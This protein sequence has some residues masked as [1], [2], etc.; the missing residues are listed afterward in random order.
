MAHHTRLAGWKSIARHFGHDIR[1]AQRWTRDRRMPVH[2]VPGGAGGRVFA[3]ADELDA[4]LRAD[5]TASTLRGPGITLA[6]RLPVARSNGSAPFAAQPLPPGLLVLP[7]EYIA[8]Q[9]ELRFV[10]HALSEELIGRLATA[11]LHDMR[12]MSAITGRAYRAMPTFAGRISA[13]LGVRYLVEGAVRE[14]GRRWRIDIRV[15]DAERDDVLFTD[16]FA[17][18][19]RDILLMQGQ[20]AEA[21]RQHLSMQLAGDPVEC[22]W[23]REVDPAAFLCH[24]DGVQRT[25]RWTMAGWRDALDRFDEALRIDPSYAP[26]RA[27]AGGTALNMMIHAPG[28]RQEL[29]ALARGHRAA[30]GSAYGRTSAGTMLVAKL[31]LHDWRWTTMETTLSKRIGM[32]PSA[33]DPRGLINIAYLMQGRFDEARAILSPVAGLES[34]ADVAAW[35]GRTMIW[36]RR[37]DEAAACFDRA[38]ERAPGHAYA[39]F[40]RFMAAVYAGDLPAAREL[41]RSYPRDLLA[42]YVEFFDAMLAVM[43]G[44]PRLAHRHWAALAAKARAG[45]AWWYH[46]A[47]V[48]AALG[49]SDRALTELR[50]SMRRRETHASLAAVDPLLDG[51]RARREF[52]AALQT[53]NLP[54]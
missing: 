53:M 2:R 4:W 42:P 38:L 13:D 8:A 16:R 39:S 50:R 37:F 45:H 43:R 52:R 24:L 11:R 31:A 19:G 9:P 30:L 27:A 44:Q 15:V 1:T 28:K 17:C 33:V 12:V 35:Q 41:R 26:A 51:L 49:E 3:Y 54:H 5:A 23:T 48:S 36:A 34:S 22:E 40:M 21:V 6:P 10:A 32:V 20:V 46:A 29:D 7:F 18:G 47:R 14:A 25:R